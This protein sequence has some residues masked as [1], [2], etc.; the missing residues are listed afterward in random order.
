MDFL[1]VLTVGFRLPF[2]LVILRHQRRRLISLTVTANPAA[3]WIAR[4]ITNAFPWDEHR[5]T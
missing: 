3:E 2:V 4:Q 5:T 1:I